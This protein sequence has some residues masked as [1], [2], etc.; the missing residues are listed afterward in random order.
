MV[1][2]RTPD[3]ARRQQVVK[4]RRRGLTVAEI[5]RQLGVSRQ[6]VSQLIQYAALPTFRGVPCSCCHQF[7]LS[8]AALPE[9]RPGALCLRCL[10]QTPDSTLGQRLRAF[11][12]AAGLSHSAVAW[13]AGV[14]RLTAFCAE[15]ALGSA[16]PGPLRQDSPRGGDT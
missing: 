6:A 13:L 8:P 16:R 15:R 1:K 9:D 3:Y 2:G 10:E 11:R 12:L 14:S 5:G 7:I 4:L